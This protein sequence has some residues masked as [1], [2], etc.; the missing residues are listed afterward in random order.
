VIKIGIMTPAK[1]MRYLNKFDTSAK[2]TK[3]RDE[4]MQ[5]ASSQSIG[6]KALLT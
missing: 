1:N 2:D 4:G 6:F 3:A 5:R